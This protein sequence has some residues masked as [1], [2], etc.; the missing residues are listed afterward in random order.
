M[1]HKDVSGFFVLEEMRRIC[2]AKEEHNKGNLVGM[3]GSL[4]E[5]CV[6]SGSSG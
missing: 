2:G 6:F 4:A 1:R 5:A 3:R